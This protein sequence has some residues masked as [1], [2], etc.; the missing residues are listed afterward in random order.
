MY[1]PLGCHLDVYFEINITFYER[2]STAFS[3]SELFVLACEAQTE[4]F[5]TSALHF[6][7]LSEHSRK[8]SVLQVIQ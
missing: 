7:E 2:A 6:I 3:Q 8:A 5:C 4:T 1:L